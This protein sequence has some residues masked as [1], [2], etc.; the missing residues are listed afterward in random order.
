MSSLNPELYKRLQSVFGSVLLAKAGQAAVGKMGYDEQ[1]R[2][3]YIFSQSGEYFRVNC[4]FCKNTATP[5]T[6]KHL[7]IHH[8]W[9]VG[10]AVALSAEEEKERFWWAT[11]CYRN[12]CMKQEENRR[13][14]QNM[15]YYAL[16]RPRVS[17][18]EIGHIE[19]DVLKITGMPERCV[20]LSGLPTNHHAVQYVMGRGFDPKMLSDVYRV[21]YCESA[22]DPYRMASGRII[23]PIAMHGDDIGWQAR[24]VGD[25]DWR[26]CP[27]YY[28]NHNLSKKLVLYGFDQASSFPLAIVVEG[29]TDVW[30]IGAGAVALLGKQASTEQISLLARNWKYA[31]LLL[32]PDAS[33]ESSRT[34]QTL[35]RH[36]P[37]ES[38]V[39]PPDT[40]P[41]TLDKG[42]LWDLILIGLQRLGVN[43]EQLEKVC[44]TTS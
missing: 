34:Q 8:R 11:V 18:A 16:G 30:A 39:L 7:W 3:R 43:I 31:L 26:G 9:G 22:A 35:S 40:D 10:P 28:N 21:Q 2:W 38:L 14:L 6:G 12:G 37:T 19:T 32:D 1:I 20:L 36:I 24:Y 15:I 5:D 33:K 17:V 27:K 4:P 13:Q 23:Y 44:A 42:Y 25:T 29:A 41:A